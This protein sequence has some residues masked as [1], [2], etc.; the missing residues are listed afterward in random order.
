M[1]KACSFYSTH[2]V[3]KMMC[4]L[5]CSGKP[6]LIKENNQKGYSYIEL[7]CRKPAERIGKTRS[8]ITD[9]SVEHVS[10][11]GGRSFHLLLINLG[12]KSVCLDTGGLQC[13]SS[14]SVAQPLCPV[15]RVNQ[16][17]VVLHMLKTLWRSPQ[18]KEQSASPRLAWAVEATL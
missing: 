2:W 6:L 15:P 18:H 10:W 3:A 11:K 12:N 5:V 1:V 4:L 14:T 8:L 9:F 16:G 7:R 17:W 13:T